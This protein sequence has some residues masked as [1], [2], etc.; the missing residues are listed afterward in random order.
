MTTKVKPNKILEN[1]KTYEMKAS[2][3]P[4]LFITLPTS[5]SKLKAR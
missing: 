2:A 4:P 3:L 5:T 1:S